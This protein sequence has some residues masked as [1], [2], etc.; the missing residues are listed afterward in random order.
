MIAVDRRAYSYTQ[1]MKNKIQVACLHVP[2]QWYKTLPMISSNSGHFK[3]RILIDISIIVD[4]D[5]EME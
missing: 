4:I 5:V 3:S 2:Y 1:N